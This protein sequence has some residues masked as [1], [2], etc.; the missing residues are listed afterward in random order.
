MST[1][2]FI[3]LMLKIAF[4]TFG[5]RFDFDRSAQTF[6]IVFLKSI[7][8]SDIGHADILLLLAD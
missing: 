6:Q 4:P 5:K 1:H 3:E 2:L 8:T 7:K